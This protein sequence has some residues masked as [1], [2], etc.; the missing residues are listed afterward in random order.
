MPTHKDL[1]P[2]NSTLIFPGQGSQFVGMGRDLA[3]NYPAA[4]QVFETADASLGLALSQIMW[5]GP[6]EALNDTVNTQPAL[7]VHS[8]AAFEV[9]RNLLPGFLPAMLAGHSLGELSALTAGGALAFDAGLRLVRT[10]G[11]LMRRAGELNPGGMAAVLN[12]DIPTL[13]GICL[14]A[15]RPG[16]PVQVANDNCPGQVVISGAKPAVERAMELA[17]AAGARRAI[18]LAV[19][20]AAHSELM[21]TI[22]ADWDEA[23][24]KAGLRDSAIPL[25][26][27]VNADLIS[28]AQDLRADI[29]AQMQSRV[30]WTESVTLASTRGV[31][32]YVEMGAG[33]VLLGLIKRITPEATGLTFGTAADAAQFA[34][35]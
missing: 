8:L 5:E 4:A 2:A 9:F 21:S 1:D 10:R 34:S 13:E 30:R 12:L 22:Q 16:E 15:S 31:R 23:V 27:N 3:E 33:S 35:A 11:E 17:R 32:S 20:I 25:I 19:S 28:G 14:S 7:F 18:P 24:E 26:G 29:R 6:A